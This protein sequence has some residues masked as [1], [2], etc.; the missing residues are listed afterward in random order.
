VSDNFGTEPG[1]E[2]R[3]QGCQHDAL[4]YSRE[5]EHETRM[6]CDACRSVLPRRF[7]FWP[8]GRRAREQAERAALD[9][10]RIAERDALRARLAREKDARRAVRE[11]LKVPAVFRTLAAPQRRDRVALPA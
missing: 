10:P 8:G 2:L 3:S 11:A 1:L 4:L 9:A 6:I 5:L 7:G